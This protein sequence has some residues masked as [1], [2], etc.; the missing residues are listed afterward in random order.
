M[1]NSIMKRISSD[2]SL[3][4]V[5]RLRTKLNRP[6]QC[7]LNYNFYRAQYTITCAACEKAKEKEQKKQFCGVFP[8]ITL[9]HPATSRYDICFSYDVRLPP[10]GL[11]SALFAFY[12]A[13]IRLLSGMLET[14]DLSQSP[15]DAQEE[16]ERL[17]LFSISW[18]IGG[19][20]EPDDRFRYCMRK[21][22]VLH[23]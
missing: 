17:F 4:K 11:L 8:T 5:E 3:L 10:S 2:I 7:R 6:G 12:K 9:A 14:A 21:P 13:A 1:Y 23:M 19:L 16:L 22:A 15:G 20:M 18:A